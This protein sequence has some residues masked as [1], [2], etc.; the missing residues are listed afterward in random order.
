MEE[1]NI[2][3]IGAGVI[4]L[5]IASELSERYED[6]IVLERHNSFGQ[7]I[8]SRNSEVVHAGIYYP[9]GSLKARLCV[10][11]EVV[12]AG[13]YYPEGSLKA[14]LCVEGMERLY[15]ACER[16]SIPHKITGKLIVATG[17]EELNAL[18]TFFKKGKENNVKCLSMLDKNDAK[19]I[20]PDTNAIAAV[21]SPNTGII[22]SHSLM[23]HFLNKA[24]AKGVIVAYN[25]EAAIIDK[26]KDA[27]IVGI[28]EEDYRIKSRVVINCAGLSAHHIASLAGIDIHKNRYGLKLCKGSYFSYA[29]PSP[30][31][32]LV[33]PV[34]NKELTGLGIHAT[35]D[36]GGRL[37]FGPDTEYVDAIDYEVDIDK[38]DKFYEGA[39]R[40]I[41]CLDKDAFIPDMAGVRPK[42]Y[43]KGEPVRDFIITDEWDNDLAGL[44]NL[45]GIESP[46]L[47]ASMAIAREVGRIILKAQYC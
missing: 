10:D 38:R 47:T 24:S 44:I 43:G 20:E 2:T 18:E 42:L 16:F 29:K 27:F 7:E 25:S 15:K 46:G 40:L 4:G 14:R 21:Y 5:A 32:M 28:K 3:I 1:V 13:I 9:E 6:I 33:Y 12:H 31:K 8:S 11:S 34:P 22:D 26:E 19:K 23:K 41:P 36:L 30:V 39:S 45:I 35:L 37:R 17:Q